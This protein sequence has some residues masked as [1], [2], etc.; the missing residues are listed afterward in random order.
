MSLPILYTDDLGTESYY[1]FD[2]QVESAIAQIGAEIGEDLSGCEWHPFL[3]V[4]EDAT[5]WG[6][7][8]NGCGYHAHSDEVI[9]EIGRQLIAERKLPPAQWDGEPHISDLADQYIGRA[10]ANGEPFSE[11]LSDW[12][13]AQAKQEVQQ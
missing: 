13:S 7:Q 5:W 2:H 4:C 12:A 11:S 1:V 9:D 3:A 8:Y 6:R 10:V